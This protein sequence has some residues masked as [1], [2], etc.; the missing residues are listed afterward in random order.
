MLRKPRS[1]K[2]SSMIAQGGVMVR[3]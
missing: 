2:G 1:D 3:F